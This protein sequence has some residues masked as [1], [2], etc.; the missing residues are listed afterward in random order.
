M[1]L[2]PNQRVTLTSD[3]NGNIIENAQFNSLS[4]EQKLKARNYAKDVSQAQSTAIEV[5]MELL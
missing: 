4:S 5:S 2:N 3:S 1:T